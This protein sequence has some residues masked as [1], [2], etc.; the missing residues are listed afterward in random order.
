MQCGSSGL[1]QLGAAAIVAIAAA[2]CGGATPTAP[3]TPSP[4]TGTPPRIFTGPG[5]I[6]IASDE[7]ECTAK[8]AA[9]GTQ[10]PRAATRIT[11]SEDGGAWSVRADT[12][13]SGSLE[14]RLLITDTASSVSTLEGT[15]RGM[16]IDQVNL[17]R[18]P[19]ATPATRPT[20]T[21]VDEGTLTG[22]YYAQSQGALGTVAGR[23][24]YR[25]TQGGLMTCTGATWILVSLN[26]RSQ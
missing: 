15:I 24:Q 10:R 4:G 25:D 20:A 16:A 1:R 18:P 23:V 22:T 19:S 14:L 3:R 9:W 12:E 21:V 13:A 26:G 2:G 11:V 5:V 7:T 8:T 17:L 6:D